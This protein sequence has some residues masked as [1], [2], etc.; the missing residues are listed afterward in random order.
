MN[1]GRSR[2]AEGSLRSVP[3][4]F[5]PVFQILGGFAVLKPLA[6]ELAVV[7]APSCAGCNAAS[8]YLNNNKYGLTTADASS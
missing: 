6:I 8:V 2:L 7:Y 4:I 3:G 5:E 1:R